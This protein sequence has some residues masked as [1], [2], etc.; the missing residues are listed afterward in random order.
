MRKG[1]FAVAVLLCAASAQAGVLNG[2]AGAYMAWTGT[3]AFNNG[4]GV[5]GT[6]DYCVF[7]PGA[8]SDSSYTQAPGQF[9]YAY[10]VFSTGSDA[11]SSFAMMVQNAAHTDGT[12]ADLAG[13]G[14][15]SSIISAGAEV[16]WVFDSPGVDT[17]QSSVGLVFQSPNVPEWL[18]GTVVDGGG[19]AYAYPLPAP[20]AVIPEPATMTLLGIGAMALL[21][22]RRA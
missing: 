6:I 5:S 14:A 8:F 2:N 12:M 20:S 22:R 4:S 7:R 15:L 3:Q 21:R 1:L 11:L 19:F 16:E 18:L 10:Q 9:V 17:G 13:V